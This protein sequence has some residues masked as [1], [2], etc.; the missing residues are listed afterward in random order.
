VEFHK[1]Y[2]GIPQ[3]VLWNFTFGFVEFHKEFFGISQGVM[4]NSTKNIFASVF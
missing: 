3:G 2:C 1:G 4:W